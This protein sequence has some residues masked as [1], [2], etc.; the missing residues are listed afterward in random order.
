[1]ATGWLGATGWAFHRRHTTLGRALGNSLVLAALVPTLTNFC[2]PSFVHGLLF[3]KPAACSRT[4]DRPHAG[5]LAVDGQPAAPSGP[6]GGSRP[7]ARATGR[8]G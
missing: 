6:S 7:A 4:A 1:V 2:I 8:G 3:G 5:T